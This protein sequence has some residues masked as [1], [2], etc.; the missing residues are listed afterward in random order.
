MNSNEFNSAEGLFVRHRIEVSRSPAL[1]DVAI[2]SID[3]AGSPGELNSFVLKELG[4]S[5]EMLPKREELKAGFKYLH[6]KG[7]KGIL[8][9]V[10]V[11]EESTRILLKK[12]LTK[13]IREMYR[14]LIGS[15]WI[16]LMGT[17][18][19][20]LKLE[21]SYKVIKEV[22][23]SSREIFNFNTEF[24]LS[25]PDGRNE[26]FVKK[27]RKKDS[28]STK[29][30]Q[31]KDV[32]LRNWNGKI[33]MAGANWGGEDQT[34]R[35]IRAGIWEHA[36]EDN[37]V[38]DVL[39]V[40][41]NDVI[42][43]KSFRRRNSIIVVRALGLV[44]ANPGDGYSLSVDWKV[45]A[46]DS[47]L[48]GH[49][50]YNNTIKPVAAQDR[51]VIISEIGEKWLLLFKP[52]TISTPGVT[53]TIAP[54]SAD[55]TSGE[56]HLQLFDKDVEAFAR[57]ITSKKF[58]PPLAIALF[59]K[60]GSGK[61]FF[62]GKLRLR[63]DELA[64]L[65]KKE[66]F[67]EGVAQIHF[68][69]WSYLDANLWA[70][71]MT[72][73]FDGLYSYIKADKSADHV[74]ADIKKELSNQLTITKEEVAVLEHQ[75]KSI[76]AQL[77]ALEAQR[78]ELDDALNADVST[79]ER[80]T[81]KSFLDKADENFQAKDKIRDAVINNQTYQISET[82]LREIIPTPY[83][84]KPDEAYN[85]VKSTYTFLRE[86]IRPDKIGWNL[87]WLT[88]ILL[89]IF[90]AP[91]LIRIFTTYLSNFNFLIPQVGVSLLI[92]IGAA[93]K[94]THAVY[95]YLHPLV[96]SFW[97]VKVNHEKA[98]ETA[99]SEFEQNEKALKLKIEKNK[100]A[101]VSVAQQIQQAKAIEAD[102]TFR[103]NNSLA[104]E[105]L[106]SFIE[107]RTSSDE[108]KKHLGI[109]STIR[110]DLEIL[111]ALFLDHNTEKKLSEQEKEN[112]KLFREKFNRPLERIVLY[113]DDL[114]R[115]PEQRVVEVL[116]AVNLLMAYPLF[117]VVVGV[118]PRWIKN[119][120]ILKY[121]SQFASQL[122]GNKLDGLEQIEAS[123]YLEKI[124][125]VPFHLKEAQP[126]AVKK[127]ITKLVTVAPPVVPEP[128]VDNLKKPDETKPPVNDL[129]R[130]SPGTLPQP[131]STK[132]EIIQPTEVL[133][134]RLT[135]SAREVELMQHF[136][137]L[138]G[139]NPRAIKRFVN[140]YHIIRAH[141]E[142]TLAVAQDQDNELLSIM[143]LLSLSCGPF[144]RLYRPY[145]SFI[146]KNQQLNTYIGKFFEPPLA[147][148]GMNF[149]TE[150]TLI[151]AN[152]SKCSDTITRNNQVIANFLT[153]QPATA[154]T[155][156]A[157]VERFTFE[158]I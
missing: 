41:A 156:I 12:N 154:A 114:D 6:F 30:P 7:K 22:L 134:Q 91:L 146:T 5:I 113:I 45:S 82:Q 102:L 25:L 87:V 67:C 143:F 26:E 126:D 20:R 32:N 53:S 47:E 17:G 24:V 13:G 109:V 101:L 58:T 36:H 23:N 48:K 89:V 59:G 130:E 158:E 52:E 56:D 64:A 110:K 37:F 62:M 66:V 1:C 69:A 76:E 90:L 79:I 106:Y 111:S 117:V 93:W 60:W 120:L 123:N 77:V 150:E 125:Q 2:V 149:T 147:S 124:F 10:T 34:D 33:Y 40:N 127:M 153:L 63:I 95:K 152:K 115:C 74:K 70:S 44:T 14:E 104:S 118:D 29:E 31:L 50:K 21:E 136:S 96:A 100:S 84:D 155:H 98:L 71:I 16:P 83:W 51:D 75:K 138:I 144:K 151:L 107:K 46:L 61:S 35:F 4:Y 8:F 148:K 145:K 72:R 65:Q 68:N 18:A 99:K 119:A 128:L 112:Q 80:T 108:Y 157:L 131:N 11:G 85:K 19:G 86:F 92:T 15:V 42:I 133:L 38:D 94:R 105:A 129:Q 28:D 140:T 78:K 57:I 141:Q 27:L 9:I 54:L 116:E 139:N 3:D 49:N 97:K 122:N 73:I 135:L 103:I 137:P 142:L 39:K 121:Q 132:P 88:L 43:L 81:L 55:S